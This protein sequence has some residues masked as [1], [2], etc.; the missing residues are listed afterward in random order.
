MIVQT[1]QPRYSPP[2]ATAFTTGQ[3]GPLTVSKTCEDIRN[4]TGWEIH[5]DDHIVIIHLQGE[6][7]D[8]ET[9]IEG[10]G[11]YR[12]PAIPGGV[13]LIPGGCRYSS[14]AFGRTIEYARLEISRQSLLQLSGNSDTPRGEL[15]WTFGI[16]DPFMFRAV[17]RLFDLW[18]STDDISLMTSESIAQALCWHLIDCYGTGRRT[19]EAVTNGL[20][21]KI[22]RRLVNFIYDNVDKRIRVRDLAKLAGITESEFFSRFHQTFGM[23]PAHYITQQRLNRACWLLGNTLREIT[24]IA[25]ETGFS[26]HSHLTTTFKKTFGITPSEFRRRQRD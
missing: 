9:Q 1:E 12:G 20:G 6:M 14:H 11:V 2:I 18:D 22:Q 13:W 15:N 16:P 3:R 17:N 5:Q 21:V 19:A 7:R 25:H 23:T 10:K 4:H 24:R 26:S 8:L